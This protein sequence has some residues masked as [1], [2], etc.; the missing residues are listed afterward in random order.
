MSHRQRRADPRRFLDL[1]L[2]TNP[3]V[4]IPPNDLSG[5]LPPPYRAADLLDSRW[6]AI[7]I[8]GHCGSGKTTHL[9]YVG[10]HLSERLSPC[11]WHLLTSDG[12]RPGPHT[13]RPLCRP[14]QADGVLD[15]SPWTSARA[16]L[17][18]E[19]QRL[20]RRGRNELATWCRD[21]PERRLVVATHEDLRPS[22][23]RCGPILSVE[24][25][26]P[27]LGYYQSLYDARIARARRTAGS[28]FP[29]EP[30]ALDAALRHSSWRPRRFI[31]LLYFV[32]ESI[33][34]PGP[35]TLD[36]IEVAL[37]EALDFLRHDPE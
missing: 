34:R 18:D 20:D 3:F 30:E 24:L 22:L 12:Q 33:D 1:G 17:I 2:R 10:A 9:V 27:D 25:G 29:I 14:G 8:L 37:D 6:K 35:V 16:L 5:G 32:F 7:Q 21:D 19:A 15:L 26:H 36:R 13:Q 4:E 31:V 23:E 28:D 11:Q